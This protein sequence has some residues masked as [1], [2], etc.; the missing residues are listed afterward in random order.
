MLETPESPPAPPRDME[1]P[2]DR[3]LRLHAT[4]ATE[5]WLEQQ[6]VTTENT[7]EADFACLTFFWTDLG[8]TY[9]QTSK[10]KRKTTID[11]YVID[12]TFELP[13]GV[14]SPDEAQISQFIKT[15]G[16]VTKKAI[17]KRQQLEINK[18]LEARAQKNPLTYTRIIKDTTTHTGPQALGDHPADN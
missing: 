16:G 1:L 4:I 13:K 5:R 2:K 18:G 7:P 14:P 10:P 11:Q 6:S 8:I 17:Q 12:H 3:A 9:L 15:V